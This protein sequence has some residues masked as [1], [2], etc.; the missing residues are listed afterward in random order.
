M[1]E[2]VNKSKLCDLFT[3]NTGIDIMFPKNKL[4]KTMTWWSLFSS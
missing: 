3:N 2:G 1:K 4:L